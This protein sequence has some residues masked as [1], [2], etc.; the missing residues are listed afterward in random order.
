MTFESVKEYGFRELAWTN[1]IIFKTTVKNLIMQLP[2]ILHPGIAPRIKK[3]Y[4]NQ[5]FTFY[6]KTLNIPPR[7]SKVALQ[8]FL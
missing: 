2:L 3:I 7:R 4:K 6:A 5:I 8:R 1:Q